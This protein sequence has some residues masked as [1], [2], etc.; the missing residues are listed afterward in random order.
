MDKQQEIKVLSELK[1][2]ETYFADQFSQE[3][4]DQMIQN[5][6]NDFPLLCNTEYMKLSSIECSLIRRVLELYKQQIDN[7]H[8]FLV[9][10]DQIRANKG[11]SQKIDTIIEKLIKNGAR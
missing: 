11:I 9:T 4:I 5:I 6:T 1:N 8:K 2:S 10:D 3:E 7:I